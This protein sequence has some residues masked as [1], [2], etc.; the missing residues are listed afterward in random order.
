MGPNSVAGNGSIT[1][2][3]DTAA[4]STI[5]PRSGLLNG[6]DAIWVGTRTS[7]GVDTCASPLLD[8]QVSWRKISSG[9]RGRPDSPKAA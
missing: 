5:E 4:T 2:P 1:P 3:R 8:V 6:L 9:D 7:N